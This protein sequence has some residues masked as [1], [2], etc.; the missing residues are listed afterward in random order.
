LKSIFSLIP[1]WNGDVIY[2]GEN[3][4]NRGTK[5][6]VNNGIVFVP[7]G[8]RVFDEMTVLENLE[9]GGLHLPK[10]RF[11]EEL[12]KIWE[13]F[14]ELEKRKKTELRKTEWRRETN[15]GPWQGSDHQP[16]NAS[17]G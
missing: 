5:A 13:L 15:A 16:E 14:P 9:I 8:N 2:N 10:D 11:K 7:Q 1:V 17:Y 4:T 6:N 12:K 3:I